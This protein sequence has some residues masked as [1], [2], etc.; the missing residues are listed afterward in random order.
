[1]LRSVVR[2]GSVALPFLPWEVIRR[3]MEAILARGLQVIDYETARS[4]WAK[5]PRED[6]VDVNFKF[7]FFRR[8][9]S[10]ET[11]TQAAAITK[12]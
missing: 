4:V 10:A 6:G 7:P 8:R 3:N 12:P 1:M 2:P 9:V 5:M 11:P